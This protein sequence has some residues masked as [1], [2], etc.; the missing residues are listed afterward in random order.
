MLD[1]VCQKQGI[2]RL[3]T[4]AKQD[5]HSIVIEGYKASGKTY[6][7]KW[8]AKMLNIS[9]VV[10]VPA[11]V[12]DIKSAFDQF[13]QV[14]N[15]VAIVVENLDS[16][17]PACSYVLLKF[18]EEPSSNLYIVVTCESIEN[19]PDTIVSR[20]MTVSLQPPVKLDIDLYAKSKHIDKYEQ[21]K[22]T[23]LWKC[24]SSFADVDAVCDLTSEQYKY[25]SSWLAISKFN[26]SV[27]SLC[28]KLGHYD[29][30]SEAK[31]SI[32][33][34][35]IMECNR[36]NAHVVKSCKTCLDALSRKKI[37]SYLVLAKLAFDLKY[38]E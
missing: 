8:Y 29:D 19:I 9:D 22:R 5:K 32:I 6:L 16:G 37:A 28:W 1:F 38:C 24:V 12:N 21:L 11:K 2:A 30:G 25:I 13:A 10:A 7:A 17:V 3:S 15:N 31:S 26:D 20:S 14:S 27:N 18:M 36:S 33:V 35:Y 4:F 23:K 34:K